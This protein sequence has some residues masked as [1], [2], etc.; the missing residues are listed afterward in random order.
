MKDF[1]KLNTGRVYNAIEEATAEPETQE[2]YTQQETQ[3]PARNETKH[4]RAQRVR[5]RSQALY[6][7]EERQ[8]YLMDGKTQGRPGIK[9]ARINL[10]FYPE[11]YEYVKVMAQV[12]G[13]NIT[14]FVN[15]IIE[16]SMIDN[17]AIY[18]QAKAFKKAF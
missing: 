14:E 9:A 13:E 10:A 6:T 7:E 17:A 18:A 8:G 3:Q 2:V 4:E 5:Q 16:Q 11:Q 15:H 1:S 12:R